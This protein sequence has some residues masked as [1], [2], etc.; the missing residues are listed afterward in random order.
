MYGFGVPYRFTNLG[1]YIN[2][3]GR[4]LVVRLPMVI[5]KDLKSEEGVSKIERLRP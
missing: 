5:K 3:V 4:G 1:T 2:G